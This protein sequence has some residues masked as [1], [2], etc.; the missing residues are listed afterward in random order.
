MCIRDSTNPLAGKSSAY[1]G[2]SSAFANAYR[3]DYNEA[4]TGFR[5]L[6]GASC[7]FDQ[8][9][10]DQIYGNT[11]TL[12]DIG[13]TGGITDEDKANINRASLLEQERTGG[14]SCLLYT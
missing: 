8:G 2:L 1:E 10:L 3:P 13:Q 4:D 11:K 9:Q 14:Y 6:S 12:T 5:K 7:G